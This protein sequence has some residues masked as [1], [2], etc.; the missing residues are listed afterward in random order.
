MIRNRFLL[1][2]IKGLLVL[3]VGLL[4]GC[5]AF[6]SSKRMDMSPFSENTSTMFVEVARISRPFPWENAKPY[7]NSSDFED[8]RQRGATVIGAFRGI[9]MYSNQVVALNNAKMKDKE[10]KY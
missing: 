1:L 3:S 6:Q 2:G 7:V 4:A 10:K 5:A 9:V 8:F